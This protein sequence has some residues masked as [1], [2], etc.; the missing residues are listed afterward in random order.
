MRNAEA[1]V[2][3]AVG[4]RWEALWGPGGRRSVRCVFK[5][6]RHF[7]EQSLARF[8]GLCCVVFMITYGVFSG[9]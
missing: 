1:K 6:D 5:R 7:F 4:P 9:T 8:F 3:R 2:C